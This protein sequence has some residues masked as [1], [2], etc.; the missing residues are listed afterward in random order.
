MTKTLL[1]HGADPEAED[2]EG[3]TP[4]QRAEDRGHKQVLNQF[5]EHQKRLSGDGYE[6]SS[7]KLDFH[8]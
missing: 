4:R 1:E 3:R 2:D 5:V 7:N 8:R 6:R